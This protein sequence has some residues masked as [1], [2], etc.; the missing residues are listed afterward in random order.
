MPIHNFFLLIYKSRHF[1]V[2]VNTYVWYLIRPVLT[3]RFCWNF[4]GWI[5]HFEPQN[6]ARKMMSYLFLFKFQLNFPIQ[7][8]LKICILYEIEWIEFSQR[9]Q[10]NLG[11]KS[12]SLN[13]EPEI[14]EIPSKLDADHTIWSE[15]SILYWK[16][17]QI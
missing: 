4:E 1:H 16:N 13:P 8:A 6:D 9:F 3:M 2:P 15:F 17:V 10:Q 14:F 5:S 12:Q 7:R 11:F